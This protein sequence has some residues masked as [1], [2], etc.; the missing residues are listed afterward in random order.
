MKIIKSL[1]SDRSLSSLSTKELKTV[2]GGGI[3]DYVP[4]VTKKVSNIIAGDPPPEIESSF[5]C[6]FR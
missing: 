4:P 5:R 3:G 1:K 2:K 6:A